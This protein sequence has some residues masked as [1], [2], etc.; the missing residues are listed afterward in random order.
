MKL[1][2]IVFLSFVSN[3]SWAFEMTTVSE[4]ERTGKTVLHQFNARAISKESARHIC[5]QSALTAENTIINVKN[6]MVGNGAIFEQL[7]R[8]STPAGLSLFNAVNEFMET[9]RV[10]A[11]FNY[12]DGSL[13]C[14]VSAEFKL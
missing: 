9:T 14:V 1:V 12:Y 2:L 4:A 3:F 10:Y 6:S 13:Y 5:E 8:K 11:G 7:G